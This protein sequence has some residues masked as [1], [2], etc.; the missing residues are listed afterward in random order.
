M[1]IQPL[2]QSVVPPTDQLGSGWW[3]LTASSQYLVTTCHSVS[4]Y[5]TGYARECEYDLSKS[6]EKQQLFATA[7]HFV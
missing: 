3:C 1:G 7:L 5:K 4:P 6:T 2:L